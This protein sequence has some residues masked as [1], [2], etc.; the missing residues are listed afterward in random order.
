[1]QSVT[2]ATGQTKRGPARWIRAAAL[3]TALLIATAALLPARTLSAAAPEVA[4][5]A[6]PNAAPQAA[7]AQETI[8]TVRVNALNLR[9]G[10][11]TNFSVITTLP[12]GTELKLL[13]RF[14]NGFISVETVATPRRTGFVS[15]SSTFVTCATSLAPTE[16]V[17]TR[18]VIS[19]P[20]GGG[21]VQGD[22]A[23]DE[24]ELLAGFIFAND[25]DNR[26]DFFRNMA[27]SAEPDS[28]LLDDVNFV[29]FHVESLDYF[30]ED[31]VDENG[32]IYS[33][34]ENVHR[35]CIFGGGEPDCNVVALRNGVTWPS[36]THPIYNGAYLL[37]VDFFMGS[38]DDLQNPDSTWFINLNINSRNLRQPPGSEALLPLEM[39]LAEIAPGS[40]SSPASDAL[41][42]R[43]AAWDPNIGNVD[44]D[45]I[46]TVTLEVFN[47]AGKRVHR[48]TE[49]NVGY[50]AFAGGEPDC[51][52]LEFAEVNFRWPDGDA[53]QTGTHTLRATV[54]ADDGRAATE[55]WTFRIQ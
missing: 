45:G 6:A 9:R 18:R 30:D 43:V 29:V 51:N 14:T 34:R 21:D 5:K 12:R 36:T 28:E 27:L 49:Q 20:G 10:P 52:V 16:V 17:R 50:C 1:M 3:G 15:G 44:G 46:D 47:P 4:P 23:V 7:P 40:E 25:D 26:I 22:I 11:G 55:E 53:I 8:C 48:R 39:E 37:G 19:P 38:N 31:A 2:S 54:V 32:W 24:S 33:R 42:L 41:V 35:Y 13:Q